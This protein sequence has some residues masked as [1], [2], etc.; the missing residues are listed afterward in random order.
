[1]N[2]RPSKI[3]RFCRMVNLLLAMN[4]KVQVLVNGIRIVE[5]VNALDWDTGYQVLFV[6]LNDNSNDRD[7]FHFSFDEVNELEVRTME[8]VTIC[9]VA[10]DYCV[11]E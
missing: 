9:N 1:M 8:G 3:Q 6:Y 11:D 7:V 10:N 4:E 5:P 2:R